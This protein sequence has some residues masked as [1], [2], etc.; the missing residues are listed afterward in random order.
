MQ[1]K[2]YDEQV[3]VVAK[4]KLSGFYVDGNASLITLDDK[5]DLLDIVSA[6]GVFIDRNEAEHDPTRKQ[7]IPYAYVVHGNEIFLMGRKSTQAEA[8]LH[9]KLSLGV[10]GHINP[11]D[12]DKQAREIVFNA[13]QRE[14]EEEVVA[15]TI[16]SQ[17][18]IAVLNDDSNEVGRVHMGLVFKIILKERSCSVREKDKMDGQW[19]AVKNMA[20]YYDRME[21]WSQIIVDNLYRN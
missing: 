3:L 12:E 1:T 14:L 18:L 16:E 10:G 11:V 20:D 2:K 21:T 7:I 19:V 17:E 6:H 4:D 15:G 5:N 13:M 9:N 8:R